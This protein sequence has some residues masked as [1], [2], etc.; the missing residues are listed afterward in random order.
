MMETM[1][2]NAF[3]NDVSFK[4]LSSQADID[5]GFAAKASGQFRVDIYRKNPWNVL[6]CQ[7]YDLPMKSKDQTLPTGSR[8]SF[9]WII[10]KTILC[11]VLDFQ[12]LNFYYIES[13][14]STDFFFS[15]RGP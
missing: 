7:N 15:F 13:T 1:L 9:T 2:R 3:R 6:G 8:E 10:P 11:L 4:S 5:D 12:G 14:I